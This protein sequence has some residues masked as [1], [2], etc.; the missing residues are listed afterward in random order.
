MKSPQPGE[1]M[2]TETKL[3]AEMRISQLAQTFPCLRGKPGVAPWDVM[4]L[5]RWAMVASHGEALAVKFVLSVWNPSTDWEEFAIEQKIMK[6]GCSF[7]RFNLSE[8]MHC[9]DSANIAALAAWINRP[10]FP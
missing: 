1:T 9:W 8:A 5:L 4:K 10:F 6:K 2:T 7:S 3:T